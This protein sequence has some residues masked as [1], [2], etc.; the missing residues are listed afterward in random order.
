MNKTDRRRFAFTLIE[1]LVVIAIIAILAAIL[2]PVFAQAREKAR[3]T[4]CLSNL[5]QLGT[6]V[7]MYVQ[8]YDESMPRPWS[9]ATNACSTAET[10]NPSRYKWMDAIYPYVK[11]EQIFN[12][13]SNARQN[14]YR[15]RNGCNYGSY[16]MNSTYWGAGDNFSAPGYS[17]LPSIA[18]P[19]DTIWLGEIAT[20]ATNQWFEIHWQGPAQNPAISTTIPRTMAQMIEVHHQKTNV[21]FCDGHSKAMSLSQLAERHTVGG[22][23]VYWRFTIEED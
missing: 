4:S 15:N 23:I 9:G 19:A 3:Q 6:G 20:A 16:G 22:Q 2:F 1:L 21:T 10:A 13:P 17:P 18:Q 5:K 12:C 7:L 11:N 14:K 8:D